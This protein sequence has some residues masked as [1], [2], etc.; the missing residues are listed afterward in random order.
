[1][2]LS[3]LLSFIAV[4]T[5]ILCFALIFSLVVC[6]FSSSP[7]APATPPRPIH[8]PSVNSSF[9]A[10]PSVSPPHPLLVE[11]QQRKRHYWRLDCKCIILFQNNTSN[12]YYKV[13]TATHVCAHMSGHLLH[14]ILPSLLGDSSLGGPGGAS[15]QKLHAGSGGHE[16]SLLRAHYW[17][18][19]LLCRGGPQHPPFSAP[20]QLT[21]SAP[22]PSLPQPGHS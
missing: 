6:T 21:D 17:H 15:C 11:P 19:V 7:A 10:L 13:K 3:A 22:D 18:H 2:P 8:S 5:T 16:P 12:K 14:H 20:Q 9:A 1:M 4:L